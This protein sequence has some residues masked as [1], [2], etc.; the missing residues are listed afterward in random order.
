MFVSRTVYDIQAF[1][2]NGVSRNQGVNI[3][4]VFGN[5]LTHGVVFPPTLIP[6]DQDVSASFH[7]N[8]KQHSGELQNR[9]VVLVWAQKI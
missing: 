2:H 1:S 6:L 5:P 7:N 9:Q 8:N 3:C 4:S